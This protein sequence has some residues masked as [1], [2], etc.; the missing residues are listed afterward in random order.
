M[1]GILAKRKGKLAEV[2][3]NGI[4]DMREHEWEYPKL[5]V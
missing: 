5:C 3:D 4:F 2:L 1:L